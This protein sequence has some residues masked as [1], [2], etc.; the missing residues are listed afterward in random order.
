MARNARKLVLAAVAPLLVITVL[1]QVS[2]TL[3]AHEDF[4]YKWPFTP[5]SVE[6]DTRGQ[7]TSLPFSGVHGCNGGECADAFRLV[8]DG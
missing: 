2:P 1:V 7:I 3:A 6:A 8:G 5:P 4:A